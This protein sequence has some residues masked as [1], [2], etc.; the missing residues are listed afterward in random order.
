MPYV[1]TVLPLAD[2]ARAHEVL[3]TRQALG[4]VVLAV[5]R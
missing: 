1:G 2:A 5:G 4:K 3:E